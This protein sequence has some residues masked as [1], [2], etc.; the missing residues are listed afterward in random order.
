MSTR[1]KNIVTFAAVPAGGAAALPHLLQI[2]GRAVV[3]DEVRSNDARLVVTGADATNVNVLNTSGVA[4]TARVLAEHWHTYERAFG[5]VAT[6]A[7]TPQPFIPAAGIGAGT[8]QLV[9]RQV[10]S[11]DAAAIVFANL[12]GD[13][14]IMY[15]IVATFHGAP[16]FVGDVQVLPNGVLTN[17]FQRTQSWESGGS[18]L[19]ANDTALNFRTNVTMGI[20]QAV[21][22]LYAR[23]SA[24]PAR[25]WDM[26]CSAMDTPAGARATAIGGGAWVENATLIQSIELVPDSPLSAGTDVS[27]FKLSA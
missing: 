11:G 15:Q 5:N 26:K 8:W 19:G 4:V 6:Q 3:P 21:G 16:N 7:L 20:A 27:L 17:Q 14:D 1:L 9:E 25:S 10:L 2:D 22:Y 13:D 23:R 18:V 24:A 12:N